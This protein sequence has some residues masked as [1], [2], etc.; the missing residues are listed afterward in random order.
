MDL[1]PVQVEMVRVALPGR[2]EPPSCRQP[3]AA[4]QEVLIGSM[5]GVPLCPTRRIRVDMPLGWPVSP[6]PPVPTTRAARPRPQ[7]PR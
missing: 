3:P 4:D 2:A 1:P 5:A 6:P 7:R